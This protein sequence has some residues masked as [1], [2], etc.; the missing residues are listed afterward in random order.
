MRLLMVK[1]ERKRALHSLGQDQGVSVTKPKAKSQVREHESLRSLQQGAQRKEVVVAT[2]RVE[3]V[4][5]SS[6]H[7]QR[8]DSFHTGCLARLLKISG[9]RR[10]EGDEPCSES[11][12]R[13]LA[14]HQT[15]NRQV[16]LP[17]LIAKFC[18]FISCAEIC[19]YV[20]R[21][22]RIFVPTL[23]EDDDPFQ[24]RRSSRVQSTKHEMK[25]ST[26]GKTF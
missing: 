9:E 1:G 23:G 2:P 7:A 21:I 25:S 19:A 12:T 16:A 14:S 26:L 15:H 8:P 22:I 4:S 24:E 10:E 11:D 18:S 17:R 5:S 20:R 3:L 13:N 6:R